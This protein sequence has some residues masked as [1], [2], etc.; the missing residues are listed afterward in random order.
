MW[1]SSLAA[2]GSTGNSSSFLASLS[3]TSTFLP[4]NGSSRAGFSPLQST[5]F[6]S[7]LCVTTLATLQS[8]T[9]LSV[10]C[11][12]CSDSTAGCSSLMCSSKA[13]VNKSFLSSFNASVGFLPW[14]NFEVSIPVFFSALRIFLYSL[15]AFTAAA[16]LGSFGCS[17]STDFSSSPGSLSLTSISVSLVSSLPA[18]LSTACL[19]FFLLSWSS[20][21]LFKVSN[22]VLLISLVHLPFS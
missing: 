7:S 18:C 15:L 6:S 21:A 9:A 11:K 13:S 14:T 22:L 19:A 5:G 8:T 4:A 2:S 16:F 3:L 1:T 10:P 17:G 20:Q 12:T